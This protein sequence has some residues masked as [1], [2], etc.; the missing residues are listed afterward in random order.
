MV[1]LMV[2]MRLDEAS[3]CTS[4]LFDAR[5]NMPEAL[6]FTALRL[7]S[8]G[9]KDTSNQL[10]ELPEISNWVSRGISIKGKLPNSLSAA[11]SSSSKLRSCLKPR[12]FNLFALQSIDFSCGQL[13]TMRVVSPFFA[14]LS[15]S[16]KGRFFTSSEPKAFSERCNLSSAVHCERSR[17]VSL[18]FS[19]AR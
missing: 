2:S 14:T 15:S 7:R 10:K 5:F 13:S 17:E 4:S 8:L 19:T 12:S 6:L 3:T 11:R 9:K 1:Q 18:F 16:S